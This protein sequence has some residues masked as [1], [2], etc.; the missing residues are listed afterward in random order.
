MNTTKIDPIIEE[1]KVEPVVSP[2]GES[3]EETFRREWATAGAD[4][5]FQIMQFLQGRRVNEISLAEI[6]Q[7]KTF[8]RSSDKEKSALRFIAMQSEQ[9]AP[10]SE[11]D[12]RRLIET[13]EWLMQYAA[14]ETLGHAHWVAAIK[15]IPFAVAR[16]HEA[17]ANLFPKTYQA[18]I[19]FEW[20][21][22]TKGKWWMQW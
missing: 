2:L 12:V 9:W 17:D 22:A 6:E 1:P 7:T 11:E 16:A 10:L 5:G 18:P 13:D 8:A 15:G 3:A 14:G 4:W 19:L 20:I 21:W